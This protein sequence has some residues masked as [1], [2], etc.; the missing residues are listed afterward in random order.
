MDEANIRTPEQFFS[1]CVLPD[2]EGQRGSVIL[3]L[4]DREIT[5]ESENDAEAFIIN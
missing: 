2:K 4:S 3:S 1:A 5:Y